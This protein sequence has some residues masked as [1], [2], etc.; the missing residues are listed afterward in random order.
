MATKTAKADAKPKT[1]EADGL[2]REIKRFMSIV[3]FH[4]DRLKA[5]PV[6]AGLTYWQTVQRHKEIAALNKTFNA[7]AKLDEMFVPKADNPD[8]VFEEDID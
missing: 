5:E 1:T 2:Y 6:P 8:L 4:A 3:E 7:L